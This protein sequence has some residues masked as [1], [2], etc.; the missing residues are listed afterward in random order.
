MVY[1]CIVCD[2]DIIGK[3]IINM[4]GDHIHSG[5]CFDKHYDSLPLFIKNRIERHFSESE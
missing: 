2:Y 4:H 5:E 3:H 1:K